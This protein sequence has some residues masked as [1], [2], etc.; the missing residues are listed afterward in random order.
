MPASSSAWRTFLALVGGLL[1]LGGVGLHADTDPAIR[2]T[3]AVVYRGT[4]EITHA[5]DYRFPVVRLASG[6]R[7]RIILRPESSCFFYVMLHDA[8]KDLVVLFPE[9]SRFPSAPFQADTTCSLP[10]GERWY[11]L[12]E[13]G[14]TEV[15]YLIASDHRLK[16]LEASVA[17]YRALGHDRGDDRLGALKQAVLDEIRRLVVET[18]PLAEAAHKPLAVAGDFRG[19]SAEEEIPGISVLARNVYVRTIRLQH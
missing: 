10:D 4:D 17:A 12:D 6:D 18:S 13:D 11:R 1:L 19:I 15:F 9:A 7:L 8:Q 3:W 14:G 16:A 2:L 5:I